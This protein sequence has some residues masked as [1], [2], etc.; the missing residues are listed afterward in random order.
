M[1]RIH[2]S[3]YCLNPLLKGST[4]YGR[5]ERPL[6]CNCQ[7]YITRSCYCILGSAIPYEMPLH[8][9]LGVVTL[10]WRQVSGPHKRLTIFSMSYGG[11]LV[12]SWSFIIGML[13]DLLI[14]SQT[15]Y[16][17]VTH[18]LHPPFHKSCG[19]LHHSWDIFLEPP[20]P[21][22]TYIC[23]NTWSCGL[24]RWTS[25][26]SPSHTLICWNS[27]YVGWTFFLSLHEPCGGWGIHN[28]LIDCW[29]VSGY[30]RDFDMVTPSQ[31][32]I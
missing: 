10:A 9:H 6:P 24:N 16:Y 18:S 21:C 20:F 2:V 22:I 3:C 8:L 30:W 29:L 12:T 17:T 19:S 28:I 5:R 32:H 31:A 13:N 4:N 15:I 7:L 27:C 1:E 25:Y 23:S 14:V 26:G 11:E